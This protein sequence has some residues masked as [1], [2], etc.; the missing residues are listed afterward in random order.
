V[1]RR[2][3]TGPGADLW[4]DPG[5]VFP[6]V[7]LQSDDPSWYFTQRVVECLVSA[8]AAVTEAPL[9]NERLVATAKDLLSEADHLYNRELLAGS[10]SSGVTMR[11]N[12]ERLDARLERAREVINTVPGTTMAI[13]YEVL[14]EIDE[15][16]TARQGSDRLA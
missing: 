9:R 15:L 10:A 2:L 12:L 13:L 7:P 16:A 5:N 11:A 14:L 1:A 3:T 8:A 6:S 4:D